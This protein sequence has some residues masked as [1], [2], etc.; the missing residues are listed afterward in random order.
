M[1]PILADLGP[2]HVKALELFGNASSGAGLTSV[3]ALAGVHRSLPLENERS[4]DP[5]TVVAID[6]GGNRLSETITICQH[7][8]V[9]PRPSPNHVQVVQSYATRLTSNLA[10]SGMVPLAFEI[11][12]FTPTPVNILP[13]APLPGDC[14][15]KIGGKGGTGASCLI[16]ATV[17]FPSTMGSTRA[18]TTAGP[19]VSRAITRTVPLAALSAAV[20]LQ[21][22]G[23]GVCLAA[24][25]SAVPA[26]VNFQKAAA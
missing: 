24:S 12:G 15:V 25:P 5:A 7:G 13:S 16:G 6:V 21:T 23:I 26:S 22:Y 9:R 11:S 4:E 8:P 20:G 18:Q 2:I 17:L 14:V 10:G 19:K 1:P 3:T